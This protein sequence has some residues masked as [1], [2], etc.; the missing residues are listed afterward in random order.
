MEWLIILTLIILSITLI[1]IEVI[2][3][4]GTTIV[5]I[6]GF[7]I[8]GLGVY[9]SFVNYGAGTGTIVLLSTVVLTGIILIIAFK[10][11]VWKKLSLKKVS[12]S[13]VNEEFVIELKPGQNG[14][15]ISALRPVGKA[16]FGDKEYEVKTVG[17]Y[18]D[19]G[20]KI[21]IISISGRQIL[22]EP[23]K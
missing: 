5:G 4:P 1:V 22:V 10:S 7:G 21:T 14:V 8:G 19:A 17:D 16:E 2:F 15:A 18:V 13:K 11:G 3:I 9:L 20:K 12:G 23:I 6:I